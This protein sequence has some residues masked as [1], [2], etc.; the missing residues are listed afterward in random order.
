[1]IGSWGESSRRGGVTQVLMRSPGST[2]LGAAATASSPVCK[3]L[4]LKMNAST[5][6]E[7]IRE[8]IVSSKSSNIHFPENKIK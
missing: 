6:T 5:G 8:N 1:M 3:I 2:A 4:R 7:V